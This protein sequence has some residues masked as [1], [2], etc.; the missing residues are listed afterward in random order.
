MG[1]HAIT[2]YAEPGTK[3]GP[4]SKL[5]RQL[6]MTWEDFDLRPQLRSSIVFPDCTL[7][8]TNQFGFLTEQVA[9]AFPS[10]IDGF[11]RLVQRIADH[12]ALN[13]ERTV[14]S[15]RQVVSEYIRDPLLVDMLVLAVDQTTGA[16]QQNGTFAALNTVSF[17]VDRKQA[18]LLQLARSRG[19]NMTLVLRHPDKEKGDEHWTPDQV[20]ALLQNPDGAPGTGD[21]FVPG[22]PIKQEKEAKTPAPPAKLTT[23]TVQLPMANEDIPAGTELTVDVLKKFTMREIPAPPPANAVL[24][25]EA[26]QGKVLQKD[27]VANQWLPKSFIGNF[28]IAK[29]VPKFQQDLKPGPEVVPEKVDLGP[30]K[31]VHDILV[32]GG[33]GHKI[34]RYEEKKPGEDRKST[35][36]NSSHRT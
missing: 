16:P 28:G 35:R 34:F 19:C 18:L 4:L 24:D 31:R 30:A 11:R 7:F 12:D 29:D 13:L 20:Q 5:L 33:S 9:S 26:L 10:Q 23:E 1:L 27:V 8:F 14:L 36:L 3:Q 32:V 2:N 21:S 6:R 22:D 15:A 25:L 17:A